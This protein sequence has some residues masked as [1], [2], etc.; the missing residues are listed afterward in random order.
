MAGFAVVDGDTISAS[1]SLPAPSADDSRSL[2]ELYRQAHDLI[3]SY[4]PERLALLRSE[5]RN[6][7][8]LGI[9]RQ[10]EG[11]ILAAAG[12][13]DCS[14]CEWKTAVALR[15]PV[16]LG[17]TAPNPETYKAIIAMIAGADGVAVE[18]GYAAAAALAA[19][20]A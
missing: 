14:L 10:A 16:G 8:T 7:K 9:A 19:L 2:A 12:H 6:A 18:I 11:A 17:G 5:Q 20:R 3:G 4:R 13:R 15:R 1:S